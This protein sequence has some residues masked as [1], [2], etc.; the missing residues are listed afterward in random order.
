MER[1]EYKVKEKEMKEND[2]VHTRTGWK[3]ITKETVNK[4]DE[5]IKGRIK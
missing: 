5:K 3:K 1:K 2:N 4:R